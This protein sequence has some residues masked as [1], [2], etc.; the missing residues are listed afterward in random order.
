MRAPRIS[1]TLAAAALLFA[2]HPA[3]AEEPAPSVSARESNVTDFLFN[4]TH[5]LA[6]VEAGI[7][8]LPTA[9]ISDG[10]KGGETPFGAI[11]KGDATIQ[12]G[13]HL[14]YRGG[15]S[16]AI[17]AGALFAP[18]PTSDNLTPSVS[19]LQRTHSRSYLFLGTEGRFIPVHVKQFE[20]WIGFTIGGIIIADRYVTNSGD[21]VAPI[22]GTKEITIRTE[23]FAAGLQI[24]LDWLFTERI[25][26]G[27]AARLDR[28]V[29]PT[30]ATCAPT[31]ACST[32]AGPITAVELALKIGYRIP[33]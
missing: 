10:H 4:R 33:L 3:A 5:T 12:T 16:W 27:L 21:D 6:E 18:R 31:G 28:W 17:G 11:G 2:A 26:A 23:G 30:A 24:G 32:L 19:G 29:L 7:L 20:A 25:V 8:A 9:P 22:L 13:L 14:L 15:R 1:I